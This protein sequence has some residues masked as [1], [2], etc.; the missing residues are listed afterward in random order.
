M[1][2]SPWAFT[3]ETSY[4]PNKFVIST[5]LYPDSP[6]RGAVE[7]RAG[8]PADHAYFHIGGTASRVSRQSSLDAK[9]HGTVRFL[10]MLTV[11]AKSGD[12]VAMIARA[13]SQLAM[14]VAVKRALPRRLR[15]QTA[16]SSAMLRS[17]CPFCESYKS[18]GPSNLSSREKA[19]K[20]FVHFP[21]SPAGTA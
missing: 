6:P 15:L 12:L 11:R 18:V 9:N 20:S 13:R 7:R 8:N 16:G 10:N 4:L 5:G 1:G 14:N 19:T 2:F 21:S 17:G 3:E